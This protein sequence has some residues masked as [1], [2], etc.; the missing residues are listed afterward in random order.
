MR[1]YRAVTRDAWAFLV[2]NGCDS[3]QPY[4]PNE[5]AA[6]RNWLDSR[7]WIPWK[8]VRSVLCLACGGGQQAP[9]FASTGCDVTLLD[10]S[11][12]QLRI[13]QQAARQ[14]QFSIHCIEG[15]MLRMQSLYGRDFDLV[16]QAVSAC[17]VPDVKKLY[18]EVFRVLKPG[19]YYYVHHWN[20][21]HVQLAE[22]GAWDGGAYRVGRP[23][24]P[25]KPVSAAMAW[26][27][28][29]GQPTRNCWH[30]IHP[31]SHLIGGLCDAGFS[32]LHFDESQDAD[33]TAEP[34][35][36]RHLAAYLPAFF[37]LFARRRGVAASGQAATATPESSR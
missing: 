3:T 31:L 29:T 26:D 21:V 32:I 11:P 27:E 8:R 14:H 28:T 37:T 33:P 5:F 16:Y 22:S 24:T 13:D 15:D 25:G 1:D 7:G 2:E 10:L 23:Q 17:Y 36:H 4:G 6:A 9:L 12:E 35:S 20:P 18:R 34:G 19:G 30:Y